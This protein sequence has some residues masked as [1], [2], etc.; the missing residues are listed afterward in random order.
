MGKEYKQ[1][2]KEVLER[3]LIPSDYA[4]AKACLEIKGET[5]IMTVASS[6]EISE[7]TVYEFVTCLG[8]LL[9]QDEE[10]QK[11]TGKPFVKEKSKRVG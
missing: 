11:V 6:Y 4:V 10:F 5:D 2:Q 9:G 8:D 1:L 3:T 7:D